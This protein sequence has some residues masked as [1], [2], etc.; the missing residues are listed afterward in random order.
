ME[1]RGFTV[2]FFGE[3]AGNPK[4]IANQFKE[5]LGSRR[6]LFPQST[7]S[8][9]SIETE[10][11]ESQKIPLIV[12]KTVENPLLLTDS[13]SLYVFTSPSNYL[14]FISLNSIPEGSKILAWGMTTAQIIVNDNREVDFILETSSYSELLKILQEL[15]H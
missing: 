1:S 15:I 10:L 7:R 4:E 11:P 12:Y 14:S 8:N 6:V 9:K 5:W 3:N 2:S 13:F